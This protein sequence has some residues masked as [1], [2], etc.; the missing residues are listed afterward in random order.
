MDKVYILKEDVNEW[1]GKYFGN[2]DLVSVDELLDII[3]NLDDEVN[4]L[5]EEIKNIKQDR[6]D[7]Y[8]PISYYEQYAINEDDFN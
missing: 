7:N 2:K 5:K 4:N 1:I 3:E 8:R 6:D